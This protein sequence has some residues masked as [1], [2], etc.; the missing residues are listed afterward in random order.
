MKTAYPQQD[1]LPFRTTQK[2][3]FS[4]HQPFF[5]GNNVYA[6]HHD[7]SIGYVA[8]AGF[9]LEKDFWVD[10]RFSQFLS[11]ITDKL[12][13][14]STSTNFKMFGMQFSYDWEP[15]NRLHFLPLIYYEGII[16]K[17]Q[18][19]FSGHEGGLGLELEYY[20]MKDWYFF[21]GGQYSK[22]FLNISAPSD[23]EKEFSRGQFFS[24]YIGTG[25][26]LW[27]RY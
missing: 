6:E 14:N 8:K 9:S 18:G 12:V 10:I 5:T 13:I 3:S 22:L 16:A 11:K 4:V 17:N 26:I 24:F 21:V 25:S 2:F 27:N 19:R 15:F 20:V 23:I 7:E 1:A